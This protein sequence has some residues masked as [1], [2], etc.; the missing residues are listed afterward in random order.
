MAKVVLITGSSSGIGR[1]TAE[2]FSK[3]GWNVAATARRIETIQNSHNVKAFRL[4]VTDESTIEEAVTA[5]L[6]E[7]GAIDVLVNNAGYGLFG[8]LEGTT[9]E[10]L[11][12]LF[13]TNVL[14]VASVTRHVLPGMRER[15]SGTIVNV[16]SIA[17]RIASPFMSGY[18]ATK[19]ALEGF[20]E[21][22]RYELSLHGIRVK[23]VE[24]AH[25][26]TDFMERSL[27][28]T[29]HPAYAAAFDNFMGWVLKEDANASSPEP[30]AEAIYRAATDQS[31]RL[32]YPV[33]GKVI[34]ALTSLFPDAIW[35]YLN[36]AGMTRPSK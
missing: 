14:G 13:R 22:L 32:R 4:D 30:V 23:L 19:F 10:Q 5:T 20:S 35:R 36:A 1:V 15:K 21:S 28:R 29:S 11:E 8:P 33:G 34:L 25:F 7:F 16:S 9:T 18:H 17:G 2:L 3:R 27:E 12:A 26:K 24:P 31:E 6:K